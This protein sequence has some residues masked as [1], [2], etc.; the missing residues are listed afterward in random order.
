MERSLTPPSSSPGSPRVTSPEYTGSAFSL[1][2]PTVPPC[3]TP[4]IYRSQ[5]LTQV[6][7]QRGLVGPWAQLDAKSH[8]NSS[9][10][11]APHS[12]SDSLGFG[13]GHPRGG[14]LLE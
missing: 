7:T 3:P 4:A 11:P 14:S 8:R 12:A 6:P 1:G 5:W 10:P 9:R 2:P 13:V